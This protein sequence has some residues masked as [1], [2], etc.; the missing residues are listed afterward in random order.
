[1]KLE[2]LVNIEPFIKSIT[3]PDKNLFRI[4][5]DTAFEVSPDSYEEIARIRDIYLEIPA[6]ELRPSQIVLFVEALLQ[7]MQTYEM[8]KTLIGVEALHFKK[9]D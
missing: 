1:M 8:T 3:P 9:S 2:D 6:I 5:S 4:W 7:T